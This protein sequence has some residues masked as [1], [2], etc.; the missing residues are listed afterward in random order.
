MVEIKQN[1]K[2]GKRFI[3]IE[4]GGR[5]TVSIKGEMRGCSRVKPPATLKVMESSI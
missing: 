1:R 2:H 4:I 3:I 5:T